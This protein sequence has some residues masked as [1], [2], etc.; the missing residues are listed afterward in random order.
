MFYYDIIP[1]NVKFF[2]VSIFPLCCYLKILFQTQEN[3]SQMFFLTVN[4]SHFKLEW[5]V[6]RAP[7]TYMSHGP[8]QLQT[9]DIKHDHQLLFLA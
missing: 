5:L 1:K 7:Y 3:T 8:F 2:M 9:Q 6:A 4:L